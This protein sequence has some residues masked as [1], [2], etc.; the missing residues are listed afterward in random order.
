[1]AVA[2]EKAGAKE[3]ASAEPKVAWTAVTAATAASGRAAVPRS[4]PASSREGPREKLLLRGASALSDAE[5]IAVL[6]GTGRRGMS[7]MDVATAM[8]EGHDG[9]VGLLARDRQEL[10]A[11]PGLGPAR[12]ALL[13][14]ALELGRRC[15]E[16]RLRGGSVLASPRAT[17]EFLQ[18]HLATRSREVFCCL[19]LDVQH[20]LLRCEDLFFGTL[21]GA[22]VYPRE[23][24]VRALQYRA[25]AVILAH[26]HPSGVAQPS[27]AD[28][29]ITGRL[30]DALALIDVRVLDHIV[31][32]RGEA[33]SFA[34][35]GLL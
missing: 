8:L 26:N 23:V 27:A 34:E 33:Y 1:M 11:E 17:R 5:L 12:V 13:H 6:L 20:R 2:K 21:D 7:A 16:Q 19:F 30:R 9:L 4:R 18:H 14:A 15:A 29:N 3:T 24:V 25:A 35:S 32:G 31:V 22:A 28:R 10:L